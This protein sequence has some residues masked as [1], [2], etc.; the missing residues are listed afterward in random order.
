[1]DIY[2]NNPNYSNYMNNPNYQE[3]YNNT[4]TEYSAEYLTL[5]CIFLLLFISIILSI[6]PCIN[7]EL[8]GEL[9]NE[10]NGELINNLEIKKIKKINNEICCICL[11]QFKINDDINKLNCNHIFHKVC[12]DKWYKFNNCPLCRTIII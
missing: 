1:M 3:N 11:E 10:L 12:L 4:S 6:L 5:L 9:N 2:P 8:N 7:N